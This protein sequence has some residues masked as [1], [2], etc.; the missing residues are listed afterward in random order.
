MVRSVT[1]ACA[2]APSGRHAA[3][4]NN[5][6]AF[7]MQFSFDW[8][9]ICEQQRTL[10]YSTRSSALPLLTGIE[11]EVYIAT[12]VRCSGSRIP[13]PE[14]TPMAAGN[15]LRGALVAA[16]WLGFAASA[17]A[18]SPSAV[19]TGYPSRLVKILAPYSSGAA[20]AVFT[21]VVADALSRMWRQQVIVD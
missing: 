11:R 8:Q 4:M 6:F 19:P 18:Q 13:I 7:F 3:A 9:Q 20:P 16:A 1:R 5:Q 2:P 10:S 14:E 15:P 21:H 12:S 17:F